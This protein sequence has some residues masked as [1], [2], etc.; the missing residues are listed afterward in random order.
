MRGRVFG[1]VADV[2]DRVRPGYPDALVDDVLGYAQA[3]PAPALEVGAGTGKATAAFAARSV[4]VTAV[5]PDAAMA[6][7]LAR[8]V[9]D[10]PGVTVVVSSFEEYP[11]PQRFGLLFSADAWHW[12]DPAVRWQRAAAALREWGTLALFWHEERFADD[13]VGTAFSGVHRR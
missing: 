8:R 12:M 13:A 3:D 4:P 11:P 1:E 10:T 6:A 7:V 9:A 5:E 2:Y